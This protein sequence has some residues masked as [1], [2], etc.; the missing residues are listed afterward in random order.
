M[1]IYIHTHM[2]KEITLAISSVHVEDT[3]HVLVWMEAGAT[4]YMSVVASMVLRYL[5]H[6]GL[7]AIHHS[8]VVDFVL[9][10]VPLFRLVELLR[11][12]AHEGVVR[13]VSYR[14]VWVCTLACGGAEWEKGERLVWKTDTESFVRQGEKTTEKHIAKI[15]ICLVRWISQ[16]LFVLL[17]FISQKADWVLQNWC[18]VALF[19]I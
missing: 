7:F 13:R 9:L 3:F 11:N 15:L 1:I 16:G 12:E 2:L 4:L 14:S 8:H 18:E 6:A 19:L 17:W 10:D 5:P